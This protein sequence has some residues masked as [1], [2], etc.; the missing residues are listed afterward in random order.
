MPG[1]LPG[2]SQS[3]KLQKKA[4]KVGFDWPDASG[5]MGKVNEELGELQASMQDG[6]AEQVA[7]ELGDLLFTCVNLARHLQ[8]DPDAALRRSN[9][10]FR[11]RFARLE[12]LAS[13]GEATGPLV[14]MPLEAMENLWQEAKKN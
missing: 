5:P 10:K 6:D 3:L 11:R 14:D 8:V 13:A 9:L 7:E 4:A 2:L 12:Q 1:N